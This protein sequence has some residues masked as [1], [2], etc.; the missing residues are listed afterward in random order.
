[1]KNVLSKAIDF[2]KV[3]HE[4]Q[5]RKGSNIPYTTH[6]FAV[7]KILEEENADLKTIIVGILHDTLEDTNTTIEEL[8]KEFG[9]EIACMVDTLSEKKGLPYND[10]KHMQSLR[11]KHACREV[12]LVKCAD[13]LSNLTDTYKD[14]QVDPN[15]WSKF[16]AGK[17]DIQ[18][19]YKETIEA[20]SEIRGTHIYNSLL[21]IY[22]KVFKGNRVVKYCTSCN[23]MKRELSPDPYDWFCDDNEVYVCGV[24]NKILS[25]YNR[26]YEKQIAPNDCP[27]EM[28]R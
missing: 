16:N 27:L 26:P 17:Q 5:T 22:D 2:A 6:I 1:M 3:K 19:H 18:T 28:E 4:G 10:R 11:I 23:F 15:V 14:L 25:E 20:L 12:K 8:T 13:C 9:V 21:D 7:A 24:T